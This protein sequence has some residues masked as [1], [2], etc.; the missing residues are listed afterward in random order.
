M[1]ISE[2]LALASAE[3]RE[4]FSSQWLGYT[5]TYGHP[6]LLEE[7]AAT[8]ESIS[9]DEVLC[10]AGAEEGIYTAMRVLLDKDD[11]VIVAVP[12][13]QAAETVPSAIC[14][15][16]AVPLDENDNWSLDPDRVKEAIRP[17]TKLVS[18]NFP[19]NPT[20]AVL[21]HGR[22]NALISLCRRHGLYLFSDEVYRLVERDQSIRLTQ[23]ADLYE[24]ALSLNVMSKAYGLPGLRIGWLASRDRELLSKMERYKHYLTICNAAPSERLAIIAL[25]AK[26]AILERNRSLLRANLR[27]LESFF[28]EFSDL[29]AWYRPQGGCVAFPKFLGTGSTDQFCEDLVARAGVLLLP[30]RIFSSAVLDTPGDR[31]RI[32]FGRKNLAEGLDA[33]RAYLRS[34]VVEP[35]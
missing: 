2:L 28:E 10:F 31:F 3:D 8:Y 12:N 6:E 34:S 20:G 35:I 26:E 4:A 17:Q 16:S 11:H 25:R 27:L 15:V 18:I 24:K 19:N 22:Y 29:F 1:S 30:P 14:S 21:D 5:Q 23:A 13:Y 32:G 7:I 9:P 33:W